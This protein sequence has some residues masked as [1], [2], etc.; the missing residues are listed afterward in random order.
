MNAPYE[1]TL[2]TTPLYVFPSLALAQNSSSFSSFSSSIKILAEPIILC[3]FGKILSITLN[4]IV[5]SVSPAAK[6]NGIKFLFLYNL[7]LRLYHFF[8]LFFLRIF[9]YF[10]LFLQIFFYI[11]SSSSF[12]R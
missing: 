5:F 10:L 8:L 3:S 12:T 1:Q 11:I 6:D 9:L 4:L 2:A 7:Q